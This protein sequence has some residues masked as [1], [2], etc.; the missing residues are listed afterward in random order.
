MVAT[1]LV[2]LFGSAACG[3]CAPARAALETLAVELG[4]ALTWVEHRSDPE[5]AHA[6]VA[7]RA[8]YYGV[9]AEPAAFVAGAAV[10]GGGDP[11]S[12][13]RAAVEAASAV[14]P[15]LVVDA[16]FF[17]EGE[18]R[19]GN[20]LVTASVPAG[21]TVPAPDDVVIRAI[22][23]EDPVGFAPRVSRLVLPATPLGISAGGES[24]A[25]AV[26]FALDA[27]WDAERLAGVIFAQRESDRSVVAAAEARVS[28]VLQ[29][30][31]EGGFDLS[32]VTLLPSFP[33]PSTGF[34][35]LGF[36]LPAADE[37]TLRILDIGGRV[38]RV[39]ASGPRARGLHP[40]TWDGTDSAGRRVPAGVFIY[41][42]ETRTRL[43]GRRL[44][45]VR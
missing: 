14:S 28:G 11:E 21:E 42:L 2:E 30:L 15:P 41:S 5:F 31:P 33:N 32:E 24:Q 10:T 16:L 39:L 1:V 29:P 18:S 9:G 40:V 45:L 34:V 20:V 22:V 36:Y 44:T 12:V 26:D 38:V 3:E 19:L 27:G 37:A 43:M 7:A 35:G 4:D 17:F 25:F 23:L 6:G 8:A 13:Y